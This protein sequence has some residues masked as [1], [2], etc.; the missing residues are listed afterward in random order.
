MYLCTYITFNFK[1]INKNDIFRKKINDYNAFK[2]K[3]KDRS[4]AGIVVIFKHRT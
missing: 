3:S 2:K 4:W 1:A